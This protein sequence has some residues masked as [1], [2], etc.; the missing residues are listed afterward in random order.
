MM[1]R[2]S[3][4]GPLVGPRSKYVVEWCADSRIACG[5]WS[6]GGLLVK[7]RAAGKMVSLWSDDRQLALVGRSAEGHIESCSAGLVGRW[8]YGGPL[9]SKMLG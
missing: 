8:S 9:L 4:S 3:D 6:N 1:Q 2:C 7:L 5:C